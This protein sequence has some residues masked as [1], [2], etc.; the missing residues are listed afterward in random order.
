[1]QVIQFIASRGYGGAE[2][3]FVDLCNN[4]SKVSDINL[5]IILLENNMIEDKLNKN[6]KIHLIKDRSRLNPFLYTQ[7]IKI[8]KN[9]IIHTHSA[10]ASEIIYKLS[11]F[12][13]FVHLATK[14]NTRKGKVFNKIKH[15]TAVSK[16]V[17]DSIKYKNKIK[18]IYNG[19]TPKILTKRD[20]HDSI[21][22]ILAVGRL[23]KIKGFN[24]LIDEISKVNKEY[25]LNIVG[26]GKEFSNLNSQIIKLGLE[27]K[28][29]LLGFKKEIPQLLSDADLVLITSLDEGFSMVALEAVYYSKL[30]LSTKVGICKEILPKKLIFDINNISQTVENVIDSYSSYEDVF[31][32]VKEKYREKFLLNNIT[33]EYIDLYRSIGQS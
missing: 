4:L 32:Y 26:E 23:D 13:E 22:N 25:I 3:V 2:K 10:K 18:I 27:R 31:L 30:L 7:I 24:L 21:F 15:V 6:I 8:V 1:M 11:K 16:S 14:H 17:A 19:I 29:R 28:V 12:V 9:K 33:N 5:E 20:H